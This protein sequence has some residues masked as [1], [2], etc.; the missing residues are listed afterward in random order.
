MKVRRD[1]NGWRKQ[2]KEKKAQEEKEK[3]SQRQALVKSLS[4]D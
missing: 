4:N 2:G 1:F 3:E